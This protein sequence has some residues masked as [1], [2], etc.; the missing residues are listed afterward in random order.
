MEFREGDDLARPECFT[1]ARDACIRP[2]ISLNRD[3]PAAKY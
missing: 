3:S 1:A 2:Q